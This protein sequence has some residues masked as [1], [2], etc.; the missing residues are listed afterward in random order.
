MIIM[1]ISY[2]RIFMTDHKNFTR[3]QLIHIFPE[4]KYFLN[5]TRDGFKGTKR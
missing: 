1:N 3:K 2:Q 5:Q 4:M